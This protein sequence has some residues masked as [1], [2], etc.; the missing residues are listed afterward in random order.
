M[1]I[2][3]TIIKEKKREYFNEA[4][5]GEFLVLCANFGVAN[6]FQHVA[7]IDQDITILDS[8]RNGLTNFLGRNLQSEVFGL[9]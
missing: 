2:I 1:L 3:N 8:T 5:S 9:T 6:E 7:V 4:V